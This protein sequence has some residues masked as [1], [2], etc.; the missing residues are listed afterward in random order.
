MASNGSAA[1]GAPLVIDCDTCV[2]RRTNACRDCVVTFLIDGEGRS[3]GG[4]SGSAVVVD[5]AE[6]RALRLLAEQGL[7]PSLRHRTSA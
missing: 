6:L 5:V 7:V 2:M 1:A 3:G 4:R